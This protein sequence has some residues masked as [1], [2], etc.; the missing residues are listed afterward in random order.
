MG[1]ILITGSSAGI[2]A[3]AAVQLT[4]QGHHVLVT[5]RS[6]EKLSAVRRRLEAVA[7]AGL[8]V[9][10]PIQADL[11][12]LKEVRR[13]ADTVISRTD[14]LDVLVNNAAI[15]PTKRRLSAEGFELGFAVNH[16][17]HFL[18]TA[19]LADRIKA[20]AGRVVT[21]S[22]DEHESGELDFD[23]LSLERDWS[24]ARSYSR[25]KLANILFTRELRKRSGLP[26]SSFHPG[27]ISTDLNRDVP[28]VRLIK[29]F[30]RLFMKRPEVGAATLVWLATDAEGAAPR[31]DYYIDRRPAQS[32]PAAGDFEAAARLW[33]VSAELT[34]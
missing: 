31:A 12:S 6:A 17:A 22:S 11:S 8:E 14:A 20:G 25:S 15:Q 30:E 3:A 29:P 18:L 33:D 24:S 23:D 34:S 27:S 9:P 10:Q 28:F 4:R 5:G 19:L 26:A 2:G 1:T 21:T 7:P 32:A 13:L 16:L